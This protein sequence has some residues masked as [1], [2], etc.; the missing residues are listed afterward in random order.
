MWPDRAFDADI[1][2]LMT[3]PL[4]PDEAPELPPELLALRDSI[5]SIDHEILELLSRRREI[6]S[7]VA[8]VKRDNAL[9]VRDRTREAAI[10]KDRQ[11]QCDRL[12]L[13]PGMVE[14]LYRLLL[15]ASR[16]QQAA[17][18]TEVPEDLPL[19]KVAVIGGNGAMGSLF[20][21]LFRDLGHEVLIADLDTS[22]RPVEAARMADAVLISVPIR[23]TLE[24]IAEIGPEC[25]EDGLLFDLT[26]TKVDPVRA[27]CESSRANVIGTH[28]MFGPGV[29]TLQE[30]RIVLVPGRLHEGSS[31]DD[32][33]RTCLTARGLSILNASAEEH[34]R[35]M[36]IV[37]VLT[38][39]STEVVGLA[40]ARLGVSVEDTLQ[41]ASPVYLIELLMTARHFCQSGDL[42]GAIHMANP[43]R[44]EIAAALEDS[45]R[46]WR[47]AVDETDQESFSRL[48]DECSAFFGSF[49]ERAMEQSSHLIDRLVERG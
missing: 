34:D 45:L 9:K 47:Q 28:P 19:R 26:S 46:S 13:H 43:N 4:P 8:K 14:S 33:L 32:W 5:D 42:Y 17:L 27:M 20:A 24:V 44:G 12:G 18:G 49:S 30:Q 23:S 48:F 38:H 39:F 3:S 16:D 6:V 1:K 41:F 35:S 37:Q 25:R 29:H 21:G 15:S 11:I 7:G 36:S 2:I 10:L 22:L 31:W 40:M